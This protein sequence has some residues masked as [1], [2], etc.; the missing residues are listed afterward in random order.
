MLLQ[1]FFANLHIS[2]TKNYGVQKKSEFAFTKGE[3]S[4]ILDL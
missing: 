1:A 3:N 4:G 2:N